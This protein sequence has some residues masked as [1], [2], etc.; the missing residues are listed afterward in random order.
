MDRP[1]KLMRLSAIACVAAGALCASAASAGNIQATHISLPKGPASVEGLGRNFVPSLAS[2]TASYGVDIAV[3][4]GAGSFRPTVGLEYDSGGGVSE[5][6]LG[7]KLGGIPS[8]RRRTQG[9]LPR[10]DAR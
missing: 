9:G 6:G 10:F 2:G 8:L 3:P 5:L 1:C 7:W 4:P